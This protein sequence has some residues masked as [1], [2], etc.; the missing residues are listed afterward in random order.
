MAIRRVKPTSPGRRF[1][2]Y[3]SFE[4]ITKTKPEKQLLKAKKKSGGRNARP[5]LLSC[6]MSTV[7]NVIS[8]HR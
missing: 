3:S 6:T 7:K 2:A 1:Q 5:E 4:E 8:W